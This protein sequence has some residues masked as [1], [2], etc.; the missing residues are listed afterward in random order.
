MIPIEKY[1]T[2]FILIFFIKLFKRVDGFTPYSEC[3][4]GR[5]TAYDEYT[6]GGSCGFGIPIMYGGAAN[7]A[8]YNLGE[9]CGICY[10]MVG[11]KGV[12]FFM[13][14]SHCP[15]GSNGGVCT[16]DML[17]FDLHRNAYK[18][19][20]EVS[21]G[22]FN[23]T[24]RMVT[25]DHQSNMVL[26]AKKDAN[27]YHFS[28][29]IKFHN[30]GLKKVYYSY[31][32]ETW[33]GL[34]REGDYNHW[35]V[36][37][38]ES[39]P[40]S[41]RLESITGEIVQTNSIHEIIANYSYDTGVQ[42][43]APTKYYEPFSLKELESPKKEDCCKL[44]DAFTD[45]YYEG[46]YLGEWQDVSSCERENA[47]TEDCYEGEK[48]VKVDLKDWKSYQFFNRIKPE[49]RR[50][51][52][53]QFAV[54]SEKACDECLKIKLDNNTFQY[55]SIKEPGQ[56]EEKIIPLEDLG[57]NDTVYQFRKF[58]F[59]GRK[60]D[61]QIF[62]FDSIK[63]IKSDF[64]D[65]GDCYADGNKHIDDTNLNQEKQNYAITISIIKFSKLLIFSILIILFSLIL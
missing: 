8:F 44:N 57:L 42:F 34:E 27:K 22:T 46:K 21:A 62:Y 49:R 28:F 43:S 32:N 61:S 16:G 35:T 30:V 20:F 12:L 31:D 47:Y 25:C 48:C 23:V 1:I 39:L 17:H 29:V 4:Q 3:T 55:L 33:S 58:L 14:D 10:E 53:I 6:E 65:Q 40:L 7:D 26:K 50:Y 60:T 15:P 13:V 64:V 54:K 52:A 11:P 51:K 56:W 9:K 2:V 59:Q 18:T 37:N 36:R 19:I 38:V 45:I 5:V 24:F 63:L 41:F